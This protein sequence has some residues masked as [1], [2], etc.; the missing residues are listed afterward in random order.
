MI[1]ETDQSRSRHTHP[2]PVVRARW[3]DHHALAAARDEEK[4]PGVSIETVRFA[5]RKISNVAPN[6]RFAMPSP[7]Y[8]L[9]D[10]DLAVCR[11]DSGID[12]LARIN[13]ALAAPARTCANRSDVHGIAGTTKSRMMLDSAASGADI[14]AMWKPRSK[15]SGAAAHSTCSTLNHCVALGSGIITVARGSTP[16]GRRARCGQHDIAAVALG[17]IPRDGHAEANMALVHGAGLSMR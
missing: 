11:L 4:P 17:D 15:P 7:R 2:V 14:V 9:A 8:P 13:Q 10:Y 12:A 3:L 1:G 6:P 5:P 16:A